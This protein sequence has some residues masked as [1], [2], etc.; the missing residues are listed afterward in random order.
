MLVAPTTFSLGA[1]ADVNGTLYAFENNTH[2]VVT[3]DLRNGKTRV[4]SNFDPAAVG[5]VAGASPVTP[6]PASLALAGIGIAALVVCRRRK[7]R[8]EFWRP[9]VSSVLAAGFGVRPRQF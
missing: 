9:R 1:V 3:L 7:C 2:Q 8:L 5:I 6:E 4:V